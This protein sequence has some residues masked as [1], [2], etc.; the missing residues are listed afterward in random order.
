MFGGVLWRAAISA[1]L[2]TAAW[3]A[4]TPPF[5]EFETRLQDYVK[6][7]GGLEKK[8]GRMP[9]R[10]SADKVH[11]HQKAL[12]EAIEQARTGARQGD[13]F[14]PDERDRFLAIIRESTVGRSGASARKAI[15]EDNPKTAQGTPPVSLAP[16]ARY[17]DGAPRST[18]PAALLLRLPRLPSGLEYHFVGKALVLLD[19]RAD[20]IVDYLPN[21]LP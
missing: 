13:L 16:N 14:T 18:V 9:A 10:A 4:S 15:L 5:R 19:S 21:A 3:P 2:V 17:P 20:L 6:L 8:L 1:W 12:A 11:A 7:T